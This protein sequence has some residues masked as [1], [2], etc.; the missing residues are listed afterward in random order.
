MSYTVYG[1]LYQKDTKRLYVYI[2]IYR[3]IS[4]KISSHISAEGTEV[5]VVEAALASW[6]QN[7]L[8]KA[9]RGSLTPIPGPV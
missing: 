7:Q 8:F 6:S 5:V 4:W 3:D 9:S 1:I 2:N